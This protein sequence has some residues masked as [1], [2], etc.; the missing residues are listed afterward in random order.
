MRPLF[1]AMKR[2]HLCGVKHL[3][4]IAQEVDLTPAR[5]DMLQVLAFHDEWGLAQPTLVTLF[6][7]SGAVVSRMLRSLTKMGLVWRYKWECDRRVKI[8][9]LT[10]DGM[11]RYA[12]MLEL[13]ISNHHLES[14][15]RDVF[16]ELDPT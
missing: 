1:F 2:M 13:H 6:G 12:E 3:R 9:H 11:N 15:E 10:A 5:F 7:V 14:V 8:V 16:A 4:P